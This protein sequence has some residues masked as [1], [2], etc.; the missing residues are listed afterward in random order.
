MTEFA[1]V[2]V[3][4]RDL[5]VD[6]GERSSIAGEEIAGRGGK[7]GIR[8]GITTRHNHLMQVV[9]RGPYGRLRFR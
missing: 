9:P 1:S 2:A 8:F 4:E 7:S 3:L 6:R 5:T